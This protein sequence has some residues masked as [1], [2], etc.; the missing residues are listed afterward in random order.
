[1]ESR[2][3]IALVLGVLSAASV[4]RA[5]HFWV[6]GFFVPDE[7]GYFYH[8]WSHALNYQGRNFFNGMEYAFVQLFRVNS[9]DK[10]VI[11][12]PLY[13]MLWF[14]IGLVSTYKILKLLGHRDDVIGYTL[15]LSLSIPVF[16]LFSVTVL[17]EPVSFA[18]IMFGIYLLVRFWKTERSS[19]SYLE[20]GIA[21]LCF[22]AAEYTRLDFAIYTLLGFI[23]VAYLAVTKHRNPAHSRIRRSLNVVLPVVLFIAI[24]FLLSFSYLNN[25]LGAAQSIASAISTPGAT[26]GSASGTPTSTTSLT[27]ST[28][29]SLTTS[30]SSTQTTSTITT[31]SSVSSTVST[32]TVSTGTTTITN[33]TATITS[34]STSIA[35]NTTTTTP[36]GPALT[37]LAYIVTSVLPKSAR[38]FTLG[39]AE[40]YGPV[41]E[42]LMLAAFALVLGLLIRRRESGLLLTAIL[43][44]L[45]LGTFVGS[46]VV[47]A[48]SSPSASSL[49]RYS[50]D[51]VPAFFLLVPMLLNK[52]RSNKIYLVIALGIL[53][54]GGI[55]A[56]QYQSLLQSN[57]SYN[58]PF[59][60][61]N[62]NFLLP[63]YRAP[64]AQL[65]DYFLTLPAS[66]PIKVVGEAV[67]YLNIS[68][69]WR[70]TPGLGRLTEVQFYPYFS[71]S[72]LRAHN[73]TTF[74]L[75]L[76][77]GA[78]S[79]LNKS[80]SFYLLIENGTLGSNSEEYPFKLQT[81]EVIYNSSS[82]Y[83]AYVR[84]AF[85]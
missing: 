38:L 41:D 9:V 40:G 20:I 52:L 17:T 72:D 70:F 26:T 67:S 27:S 2:K 6:T 39:L 79:V 42:I 3:A 11:L 21:A 28:S 45:A 60:T 74:Y 61:G 65:R 77:R 84:L 55:A 49:I 83:L 18:I 23:P 32:S 29:T 56:S 71:A 19:L 16:L 31:S 68:Y 15:L 53:L 12:M 59:L 81:V 30:R 63:Q 22:V 44:T 1:L 35:P 85:D 66:Q 37:G 8:V 54:S 51:S 14:S 5:F 58:Y 73:L 43:S 24:T 34:V 75:Y 48:P 47:F 64:Y 69:N 7:F 36:S 57:L 13:F 50:Y 78:P 80:N 33:H 25:G 10:I 62:Q 76:E 46:S 82:F 4:Y